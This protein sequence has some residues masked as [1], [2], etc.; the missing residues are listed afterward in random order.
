MIL[1]KISRTTSITVVAVMILFG[2]TDH[3]TN[4]PFE[5]PKYKPRLIV[6]SSIGTLS[7]GEAAVSWSKPLKGQK[8]DVPVLPQL[9]VFLLEDGERIIKFNNIQDSSGYFNI[10]P[11]DFSP[12]LGA[13]YAIEVLME[14]KG[15]RIFSQNCYLPEKPALGEVAINL[16]PNMPSWYTLSWSQG[17]AKEG[18]GATALYPFLLDEAGAMAT[19]AGLAAYYLSSAF[20]YT[21]GNA[22]PERK[23]DQRFDRTISKEDGTIAL[24]KSVNIRL[25]FLSPELAR[26]KKEIDEL[27]YLGESVFQTVRP[28]Y[29]NLIGAE[30]VF[31]LYNES[32][33]EA[34]F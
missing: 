34:N 9:S 13:V 11:K 23:G 32:A 29:S 27:G 33:V 28:L 25:A 30:G 26:F 4:I 10:P 17:A 2:C 7:G 21:D 8:G 3:K 16:D 14:E 24:A 22:I 1:L 6:L 20:R 12:R 5:F 19:K 18:V 15:E 31:G